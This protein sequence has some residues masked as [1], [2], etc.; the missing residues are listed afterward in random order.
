MR[1]RS[2]VSL[3]ML[4][5]A[6][7]SLLLLAGCGDSS[8]SAT[9]TSTP[10][11]TL[12]PYTPPQSNRIPDITCEQALHLL[13]QKQVAEIDIY[14]YKD[15]T[16]GDILLILFDHG[17][18]NPNAQYIADLQRGIIY[19]GQPVPTAACEAQLR[20]TAQRVNKSLP[21]DLQVIVKDLQEYQQ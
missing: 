3:L 5:L 2:V 21:S 14:K 11:S 17:K 1:N 18:R 7:V 12:E 10:A 4:S 20:Q 19:N 6:L 8:T 16:L 9:A 13:Q 15:N